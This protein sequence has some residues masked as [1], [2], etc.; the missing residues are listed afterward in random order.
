VKRRRSPKFTAAPG[1]WQVVKISLLGGEEVLR[2]CLTFD[3]AVKFAETV[4]PTFRK[5]ERVS[6]REGW[7]ASWGTDIFT[8]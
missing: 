7:V 2:S 3:Q 1:P 6:L 5:G 8:S 4:I